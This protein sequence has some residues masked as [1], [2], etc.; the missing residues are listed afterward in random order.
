MGLCVS[1]VPS[2]GLP[3]CRICGREAPA[4]WNQ[5][6]TEERGRWIW[7]GRGV[8]CRKCVVG[9]RLERM[10]YEKEREE[11]ARAKEEFYPKPTLGVTPLRRLK[12]GQQWEGTSSF[13]SSWRP[14]SS[15]RRLMSAIKKAQ[16]EE[17]GKYVGIQRK[18]TGYIPPQA[19]SAPAAPSWL[20]LQ[21]QLEEAAQAPSDP[22]ELEEQEQHQGEELLLVA[23]RAQLAALEANEGIQHV[24]EVRLQPSSL[25]TR[26]WQP[27]GQPAQ[28]SCCCLASE[29][30]SAEAEDGSA[31]EAAA[32]GCKE[33]QLEQARPVE[34]LKPPAPACDASGLAASG[35]HGDSAFLREDETSRWV[36]S[37]A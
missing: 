11:F 4:P 33:Q 30:Q 22:A 13:S 2:G 25:R 24:E 1:V 29:E 27:G 31:E 5:L 17:P 36:C 9:K 18:P 8:A 6:D 20:Q 37:S 14:S 28:P 3:R 10:K 35:C 21:G 15:L 19:S 7:H 23:G 26:S 16:Q 32:E 34:H 12:S